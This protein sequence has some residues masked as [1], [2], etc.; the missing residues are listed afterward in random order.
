ILHPALEVIY[1]NPMHASS[2]CPSRLFLTALCLVLAFGT[3]L[4]I[5]SSLFSGPTAPL[6]SLKTLH[7]QAK[8]DRIGFDEGLYRNYVSQLTTAG[9]SSYPD[10]VDHYIE[11]QKT[12]TG[13]ILPLRFLYIFAACLWHQIFGTEALASLYSVASFFSVLTLLRNTRSSMGSLLSGRS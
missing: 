9:L 8:F 12:L 13:S 7:P 11:V 6:R 4:R 1:P 5:P 10:I 3:F 2:S